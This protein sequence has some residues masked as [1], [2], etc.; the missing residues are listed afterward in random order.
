MSFRFCFELIML[1]VY[2]FRN[3]GELDGKEHGQ[4]NGDWDYIV[5]YGG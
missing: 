1:S 4:L 2:G 3:N 5:V